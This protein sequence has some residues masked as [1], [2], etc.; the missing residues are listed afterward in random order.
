MSGLNSRDVLNA[1]EITMSNKKKESINS[2]IYYD[3]AI[4]DV[5]ETVVKIIQSYTHYVNKK[6]WFK[7]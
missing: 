6:T 2:K 3:Y 5:S 7:L 4:S 1:A